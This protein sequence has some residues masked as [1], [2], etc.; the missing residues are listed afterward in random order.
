MAP[1]LSFQVANSGINIP[2][3]TYQEV[4]TATL[5]LALSLLQFMR[6]ATKALHLRVWPQYWLIHEL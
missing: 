4:S 6:H 1:L 2:Q 5:A 3:H